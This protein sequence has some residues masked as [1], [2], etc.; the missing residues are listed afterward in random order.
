MLSR[1]KGNKNMF[2]KGKFMGKGDTKSTNISLPKTVIISL[3][4]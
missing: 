4:M 3:V 1:Y 2:M